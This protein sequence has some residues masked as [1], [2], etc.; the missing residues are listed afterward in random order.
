MRASGAHTGGPPPL[1]QRD[2]QA[3]ANALDRFVARALVRR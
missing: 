3:F 1:D 2:R